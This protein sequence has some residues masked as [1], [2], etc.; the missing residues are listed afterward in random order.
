[1]PHPAPHGQVSGQPA[2]RRRAEAIDCLRALLRSRDFRDWRFRRQHPLGPFVVDFVCI[3]QALVI[4]VTTA[5]CGALPDD[6]RILLER[7][8]YRVLRFSAGE[9]LG[10]LRAVRR[11]IA[12][13]L[14]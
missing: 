2:S 3:E 4:E 14:E 6:R 9:V 11:A 10:N 1:L 7:L 12:G 5:S 13:R 8:G